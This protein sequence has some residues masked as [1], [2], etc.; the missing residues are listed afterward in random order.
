MEKQITIIM[1]VIAFGGFSYSANAQTELIYYGGVYQ[2]G[3]RLTPKT[4]KELMKNDT[5][6]LSKYK[7]GRIQY[8]VGKCIY[9]PFHFYVGLGA[10]L[11]MLSLVADNDWLS[12]ALISGGAIAMLGGGVGIFAGYLIYNGGEKRMKQAVKIYNAN[13]NSNKVSVSFGL[14]GNGVGLNVNF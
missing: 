9:Y 13:I 8:I 2:N 14:T 1:L 11:V 7:S 3:T 12:N 10:V 6:A 4:V 5:V